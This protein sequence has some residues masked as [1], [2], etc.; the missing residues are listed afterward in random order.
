[1]RKFRILNGGPE[2]G[3]KLSMQLTHDDSGCH[4]ASLKPNNLSHVGPTESV[5]TFQRQTRILQLLDP[6]SQCTTKINSRLAQSELDQEK[7]KLS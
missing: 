4:E 2:K 1:M 5:F 3:L 7:G 6:I